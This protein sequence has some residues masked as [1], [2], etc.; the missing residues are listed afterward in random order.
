MPF[1]DRIYERILKTDKSSTRDAQDTDFDE[2]LPEPDIRQ[3]FGMVLIF[4]FI[5]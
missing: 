4:S 5:F 3:Q 1:L 2:Y